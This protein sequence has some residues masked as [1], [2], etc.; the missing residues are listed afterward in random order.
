MGE[1]RK[2]HTFDPDNTDRRDGTR[3]FT[4]AEYRWATTKL[5]MRYAFGTATFAAI[6]EAIYL[7]A[8][9]TLLGD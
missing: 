1:E 8:A 9:F 6:I 3:A 4:P 2:V 7:G 5:V